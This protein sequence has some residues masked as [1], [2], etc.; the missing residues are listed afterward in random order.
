VR[1]ERSEDDLPRR[2]EEG[3]AEDPVAP[4]R[5]HIEFNRTLYGYSRQRRAKQ[6]E[7]F[8]PGPL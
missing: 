6:A 2:A 1:K 4:H 3:I 8:S 7:R 5:T